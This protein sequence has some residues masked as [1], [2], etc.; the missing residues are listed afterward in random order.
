[1]NELENRVQLIEER[2]KRVENDKAWERSKIR[3][4][5]IVIL[6]YVFATLYLM[7]ADTTKPFM[8]SIIPCFGF[9]LSMQSLKLIKKRWLNKYRK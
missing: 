9:L 1:M 6:T 8:G 4:V 3:I 7:L 2:N 5:I